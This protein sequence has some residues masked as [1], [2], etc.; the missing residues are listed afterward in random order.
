MGCY[1]LAA[2]QSP[3]LAS[4]ERFFATNT[5][6]ALM[7]DE[8]IKCWAREEGLNV[9]P[10]PLGPRSRRPLP[11]RTHPPLCKRGTFY[12]AKKR[13]FL[14]CVDMVA[15][16]Y[17]TRRTQPFRTQSISGRGCPSNMRGH[18]ENQSS[19]RDSETPYARQSRATIPARHDFDLPPGCCWTS[20]SDKGRSSFAESARDFFYRRRRRTS[21]PRCQSTWR[22]RP[23]RYRLGGNSRRG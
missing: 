4:H 8:R 16:A 9:C 3:N 20:L 5:R 12:F 21:D 17:R 13:N 23:D 22:I 15:A 7:L 18:D 1:F 6:A 19:G 2:S 11:S 14:L 10:A